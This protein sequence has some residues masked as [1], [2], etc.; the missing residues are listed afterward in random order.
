MLHPDRDKKLVLNAMLQSFNG[1]VA[2]RTYDPVARTCLNDDLNHIYMSTY[3]Y[4]FKRLFVFFY[5]VVVAALT[6]GNMG[7]VNHELLWLTG[8]A[9]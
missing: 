8:T 3:D 6:M 4:S 7:C 5:P 1:Y 9:A 2:R